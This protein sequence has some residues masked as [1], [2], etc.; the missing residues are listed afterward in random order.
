MKNCIS[1]LFILFVAI[2][3]VFSQTELY[4]L[5]SQRLHKRVRKTIEH[6]YNYDE[7]SGGF[8]KTSVNI[9]TY[10]NDGNLVE[11]YSFY[12]G[13]YGEPKPV[14][15]T[16]LYNSKEQLTEIKDVSDEIGTYSSNFIYNYDSKGNLAKKETIY[17]SGG[18]SYS[19]YTFDN[20]GRQFKEQAFDKNGKLITENTNSYNGK[21]KTNVYVSYSSQDGSIIGTYTTLYENDIK[22]TYISKGK[23]SDNRAT[24]TYDKFGNI[25]KSADV[26]KTNTYTATYDYEY[27]DKDNWIKKHYKSGKYQYFYFREIHFD[28]GE[29]T[30]SIDFDKQYINRYGNFPNV[31]IVPIV[32]KQTN[33]NTNNNTLNN[34]TNSEMPTISN[35]NWSYTYVNMKEKISD[36]SGN[37]FMTVSGKSKLDA[38]TQAKFTVEITGAETKILDYNVN[39]YYY[40]EATKRHFWLMKTTN[41]VSE[42]TLCIFQTPMVLRE[43]TVKG[44][45]M[46]GAEDNKITFYLL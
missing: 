22:T 6:Y 7:E 43:K 35:T 23:Y 45:L 25:T 29:V 24:Y 16:Y 39:S 11:N 31:I 42:G 40:D 12:E 17:K 27:D 5:E 46:M 19:I 32:K 37:I 21:N 15:K 3:S 41:N 26:G 18:G 44:L 8:V 9:N 28:N 20:K 13:K 36:I 10:N 30:G 14:K 38:G 4:N 34:N 1:F 2:S 33:Y